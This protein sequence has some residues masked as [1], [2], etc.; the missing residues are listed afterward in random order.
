MMSDFKLLIGIIQTFAKHFKHS[1]PFSYS[2]SMGTRN[3]RAPLVRPEVHLCVYLLRTYYLKPFIKTFA[4]NKPNK[5]Q[6]SEIEKGFSMPT[7]S[8]NILMII[9]MRNS[10]KQTKIAK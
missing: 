3:S 10:N 4:T 5:R 2:I 9:V 7:F 8:P 6:H 1:T